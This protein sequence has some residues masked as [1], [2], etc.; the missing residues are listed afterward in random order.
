VEPVF[1]THAAGGRGGPGR[2]AARGSTN[3]AASRSCAGRRPADRPG[4]PRPVG[5][6]PTAGSRG[7]EPVAL[8]APGRYLG[9]SGQA[10]AVAEGRRRT[11]SPV[12]CARV[13]RSTGRPR[14]ATGSDQNLGPGSQRGTGHGQQ[15]MHLHGSRRRQ[16]GGQHQAQAAQGRQGPR[17]LPV[18]RAAP[19][20]PRS[21]HLRATVQAAPQAETQAAV[22]SPPAQPP[23]GGHGPHGGRRRPGH[24]G[25]DPECQGYGGGT[26]QER[27]AEGRPQPRDP[28]VQL[29][30]PGTPAD[31]QGGGVEGRS[32]LHVADLCGV[33][34][35]GQGESQDLGLVSLYGVWT[36]GQWRPQ[37][38]SQHFGQGF[39]PGPTGLRGRGICTARGVPVRD[40][41]DP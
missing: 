31:L 32:R 13:P 39:A 12:V 15:R 14:A 35:R 10:G 40:P 4:R 25:H 23:D 5:R 41:D 11:A 29:G 27:Q 16:A 36:H 26:G 37:R 33:P 30:T 8:G 7:Q 9:L 1:G 18:E 2:A 3:E 22:R 6:P 21:M 20:P 19:V 24:Q 38:R 17:T 28:E 34:T